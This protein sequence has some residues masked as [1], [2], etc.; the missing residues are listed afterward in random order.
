MSKT[1]SKK[2]LWPTDDDV[3]ELEGDHKFAPDGRKVQQSERVGGMAPDADPEH[4]KSGASRH[5]RR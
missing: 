3:Y 1:M 2:P 4:P 5:R